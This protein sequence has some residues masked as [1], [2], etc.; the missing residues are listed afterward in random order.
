[1]IAGMMGIGREDRRGGNYVEKEGKLPAMEQR[2][3][4]NQ[5]K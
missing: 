4:D 5:I 3:S 1:M 2:A